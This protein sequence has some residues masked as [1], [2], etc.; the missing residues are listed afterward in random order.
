MKKKE[1]RNIN[2]VVRY[3]LKFEKGLTFDVV[4]YRKCLNTYYYW[5]GKRYIEYEK[6]KDRLRHANLRYL[7]YCNNKFNDI[8]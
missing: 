8:G 2:R 6:R 7:R 1:K 3:V 5:V 4:K